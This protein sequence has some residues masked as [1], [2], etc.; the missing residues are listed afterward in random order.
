MNRIYKNSVNLVYF[1]TKKQSLTCNKI[2]NVNLLRLMSTKSTVEN[3]NL[4]KQ[5]QEPTSITGISY[6]SD[7]ITDENVNKIETTPINE[8]ILPQYGFKDKKKS[9]QENVD[10]IGK[11]VFPSYEPKSIMRR[12]ER[13]REKIDP[14]DTSIIYFPGEGNYFVGMGDELSDYP[15]V[16]EMFE[17]AGRILGVNLVDICFNGPHEKLS[18]IS[19]EAIYVCSLAAAEK[20]RYERPS[21]IHS[22]V[23]VAGSSIGEITALVFTGALSFEDGLRLIQIRNKTIAKVNEIVPSGLINCLYGADSQLNLGCTSAQ[24]YLLQL[25]IPPE[26]AICQVAY[27]LFPHC[28]IIGGHEKALQFITANARDFGIRRIKRIT[29]YGSNG[30]GA[31]HTPLMYPVEKALRETIVR[32]SL[33]VPKVPLY[34]TVDHHAYHSVESIIEKLPLTISRPVK[35]EQIMR[36]LYYR[37][38][39]M[40]LPYSFELGPGKSMC[41]LMEKVNARAR[42]QM[43]SI[44][45]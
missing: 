35:M 32:M 34:S 12:L 22:C 7:S 23:G 6:P 4:K 10:L 41:H 36:N 14:W 19:D 28:K 1:L 2:L 3:E 11:L 16:L 9:L 18:Q 17:V 24:E 31:L 30:N 21:V 44:F 13:V 29:K 25:G 37:P 8:S 45:S 5:Q 38:K 33:G 27:Y 40:H 26:E 20:L 39:E 42:R 15:N 43:V